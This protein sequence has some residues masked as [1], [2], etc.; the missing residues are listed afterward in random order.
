MCFKFPFSLAWRA[1][2]FH[3]ELTYRI[4]FRTGGP[5]AWLA[6]AIWVTE[7]VVLGFGTGGNGSCVQCIKRSPPKIGNLFMIMAASEILLMKMVTVFMFVK[8]TEN[9][10]LVISTVMPPLSL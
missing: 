5:E 10:H 8:Q 6:G 1:G 9:L 4:C 7:F 2:S 3:C